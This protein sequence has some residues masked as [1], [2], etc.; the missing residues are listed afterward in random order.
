M[1]TLLDEDTLRRWIDANPGWDGSGTAIEKTFTFPGFMEAVAFVN[2]V[3][4]LAEELDHHPDLDIRYDRV[5]VGLSTHS[6]GGVT[7]MDTTL[8]AKMDGTAAT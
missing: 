4:D 6:A 1:R 7:A 3:A 5:R 8:A 2:R